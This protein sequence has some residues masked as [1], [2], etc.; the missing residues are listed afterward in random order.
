MDI[1]INAEQLRQ[2]LKEI[3]VAE[4][5]GFKFCKGIFT[6]TEAGKNVDSCN[7]EYSDLMEKAH[8]TDGRYIWGR[9]QSVTKRYKFKDGELIPIKNK[10]GK[11]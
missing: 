11:L 10:K 4:K 2:S 8:P 6:I 3:E 9:F 5:N 7:A 1:C